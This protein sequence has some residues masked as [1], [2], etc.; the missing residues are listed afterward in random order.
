MFPVNGVTQYLSHFVWL[1]SRRVLFSRLAFHFCLLPVLWV[2]VVTKEESSRKFLCYWLCSIRGVAWSGW[3]LKRP[4]VFCDLTAGR[5]VCP[6]APLGICVLFSDLPHIWLNAVN[7]FSVCFLL[8]HA[9]R[10][11]KFQPGTEPALYGCDLSHSSDSAG[12]LTLSATGKLPEFD[13]IWLS[14]SAAICKN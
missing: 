4:A 1:L 8:G 7:F 13:Q 11:W 2:G 5:G 12:S 3:W 10:M 6:W 9:Y 14:V